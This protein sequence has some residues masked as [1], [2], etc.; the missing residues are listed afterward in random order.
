[1]AG[2]VSKVPK[3]SRVGT[4]PS[5]PIVLFMPFIA[6]RKATSTCNARWARRMAEKTRRRGPWYRSLAPIELCNSTTENWRVLPLALARARKAS[7]VMA[8]TYLFHTKDLW[9]YSL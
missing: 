1:M 9:I 6:I 8:D 5:G 4:K 3:T 7:D 2:R